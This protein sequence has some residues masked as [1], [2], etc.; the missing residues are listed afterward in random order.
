[1]NS[2]G[3]QCRY[4]VRVTDPWTMRRVRIVKRAADRAADVFPLFTD[5]LLSKPMAEL[6]EA[7]GERLPAP[8]SAADHAGGDVWLHL[9]EK[10]PDWLLRAAVDPAADV[11]G[12]SPAQLDIL[13]HT[14]AVERMAAAD[15]NF[16]AGGGQQYRERLQA[17]TADFTPEFRAQVRELARELGLVGTQE[18]RASQ[19]DKTLVLGGG[20]RSP[21]LRTRYAALLRSKGFQLGDV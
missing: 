21:V 4:G 17:S 9:N 10:L 11:D 14:L 16:R 5:W 2:H 7:F 8:G 1:M 15:F 3:S 20:Y 18:P 6:L 12:L 13:R 19:Y